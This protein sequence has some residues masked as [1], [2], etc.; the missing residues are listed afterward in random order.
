M[1]D[2]VD[3]VEVFLLV[4][5]EPVGLQVLFFGASQRMV[6]VPLFDGYLLSE[7]ALDVGVVGVFL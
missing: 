6:G 2:H 4:V 7:L 1:K 5:G 3:V